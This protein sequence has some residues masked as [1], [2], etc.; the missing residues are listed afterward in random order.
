M[1]EGL[2]VLLEQFAQIIQ[3]QAEEIDLLKDEIR[4]LK[5]EKKRPTFKPSKLDQE[6]EKSR[7]DAAE[8]K[9]KT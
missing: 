3:Q 2:L 8:A 7:K 1:V 4:I 6:T 5:G 9:K